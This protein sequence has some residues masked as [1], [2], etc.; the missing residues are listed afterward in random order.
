M[1]LKVFNKDESSDAL[2]RRFVVTFGRRR[3]GSPRHWIRDHGC[4]ERYRVPVAGGRKR[5]YQ[6][7]L[8]HWDHWTGEHEWHIRTVPNFKFS[9]EW[10]VPPWTIFAFSL[11]ATLCGMA[12]L[13][14]LVHSFRSPLAR[15]AFISVLTRSSLLMTTWA[16][17]TSM[18]NKKHI[19]WFKVSGGLNFFDPIGRKKSG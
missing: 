9:G 17:I 5:I 15:S 19:S 10:H 16:M 2:R 11:V 3:F 1:N 8:E 12:S 4:S 13:K 6:W 7:H 14:I 18:K